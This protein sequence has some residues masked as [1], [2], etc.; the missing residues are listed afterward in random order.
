LEQVILGG[1]Y[2]VLDRVNTR[3]NSLSGG[4]VWATTEADR[5]QI[6]STSGV[7]KKLR[8]KLSGSPGVGR[9]YRFT[10]YIN[11]NPT[12]L[13]FDIEDL[14]VSGGDMVNGISV[15]GGNIV[16]IQCD[17]NNNPTARHATWTSVFESSAP[18]ESLLLGGTG[19]TILNKDVIEFGQISTTV[20]ALK[21]NESLM[22]QVCPTDGTIKNF[23]VKLSEDPG[24]PPDAYR[25]TIR[26]NG[27]DPLNG[28]VVSI[29]AN[30]TTGSDLIHNIDVSKGDLLTI[31]AEPLN[32]PLAIP[33]ACWGVTFEADI[34][35]ESIILGGSDDDLNNSDTEYMTLQSGLYNLRWNDAEIER[36]QL[37]QTCTIKKLYIKLS[38]NPGEAKKY[39]FTVRI[40]GSDSNVTAEVYG[41][42]TTGN[43]GILEDSVNLDE[44]LDLESD[45]TG[46]PIL[47]DAYWGL[48]SYIPPPQSKDLFAKFEAQATV[49]LKGIL[50]T[51]QSAH[52]IIKG[53]CIIKH[54]ATNAVKAVFTVSRSASANLYAKFTTQATADLAGTFIVRHAA[55]KDLYAK[56][57]LAQ[58]EELKGILIAR[59]SSSV[60]L[61][62]IS[63]IRH[64]ATRDFYAKFGSVST[65]QLKAFFVVRCCS[66][67]EIAA[68]FRVTFEG[69]VMQGINAEVLEVLGI[70]T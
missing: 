9:S 55:A 67:E 18:K 57:E 8:V 62:G 45:P 7:I 70:I 39:D 53:C 38:T 60:A 50:I 11:G 37:A 6:I 32:S 54:T 5:H 61:K 30:S 25:F 29:V 19:S 4:Y 56:F 13:T 2:Y 31:K 22:Y 59:N 1:Y 26:V 34:D 20:C 28:L 23:Y 58:W 44:Y 51:R 69:W 66:F 15:E 46:G 14:A 10:L 68:E 41:L 24:I 12:A 35:G 3:Y 65:A 36:Q 33:K 48:V 17:P 52:I 64:T 63:V 42:L 16:T 47:A 27:D 40:A 21:A 49:F 43:S